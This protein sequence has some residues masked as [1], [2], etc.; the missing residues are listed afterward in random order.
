VLTTEGPGWGKYYIGPIQFLVCFGAVIA[1]TLLAGQSMK[2][3]HPTHG[4]SSWK[5]IIA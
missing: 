3:L 4:T 1:C 5:S 2:V